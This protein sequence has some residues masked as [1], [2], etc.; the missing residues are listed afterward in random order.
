[1]IQRKLAITYIVNNTDKTFKQVE[2]I[3]IKHPLDHVVM[4]AKCIAKTNNDTSYY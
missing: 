4:M 1:M 3:F 2:K